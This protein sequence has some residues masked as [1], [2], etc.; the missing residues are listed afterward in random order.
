[1]AIVFFVSSLRQALVS[2]GAGQAETMSIPFSVHLL[3]RPRRV[4]LSETRYG[5]D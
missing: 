4:M 5:A 3:Q 1:M 2:R